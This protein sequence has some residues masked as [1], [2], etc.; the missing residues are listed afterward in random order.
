MADGFQKFE[1][2]KSISV[3]L[4]QEIEN[5]MFFCVFYRLTEG[6]FG[7]TSLPLSLSRT[8]TLHAL[9]VALGNVY[10]KVQCASMSIVTEWKKKAKPDH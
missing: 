10:W 6:F 7:Q 4:I 3:G 8:R 9:K 2:I 5:E 1:L